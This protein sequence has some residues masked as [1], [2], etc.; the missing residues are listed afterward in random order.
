M[1]VYFNKL[2]INKRIHFNTL[3]AALICA[4]AD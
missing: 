3:R 4:N 1:Y 2:I